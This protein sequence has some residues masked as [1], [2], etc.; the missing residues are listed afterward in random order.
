MGGPVPV[1]SKKVDLTIDG[2]KTSMYEQIPNEVE[3]V[4]R[5]LKCIRM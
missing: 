5:C 4:K 2:I 1:D 3:L